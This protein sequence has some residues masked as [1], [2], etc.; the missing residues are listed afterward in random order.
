[1]VSVEYTNTI[2]IVIAV[3]FI[4]QGLYIYISILTMIYVHTGSHM[5][6][7]VQL[8]ARNMLNGY[9]RPSSLFTKFVFVVWGSSC[10]LILHLH[11]LT[12]FTY[13]ILT[14]PLY[15]LMCMYVP[16]T[17]DGHICTGHKPMPSEQGECG[18]PLIGQ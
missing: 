6:N 18:G 3:V 15:L 2:I 1:M 14:T 7:Y 13:V 9:R 8:P 4:I 10:R 5:F 11:V 16:S 12:I 17:L